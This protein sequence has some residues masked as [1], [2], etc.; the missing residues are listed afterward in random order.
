MASIIR[1][2]RVFRRAKADINITPLIDVLLALIVIFMVISPLTPQGLEA[3]VPQPSSLRTVKT[4]DETLVLSLS[5]DGR[6]RLNQQDVEGSSILFRLQ[7]VLRTRSDRTLFVQ[8]DDEV[9]YNDVA[10]LIDMARGAGAD[11]IGL[12]TQ[13]IAAR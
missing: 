10:Q 11:R 2:R 4:P 13:R 12:M 6:I 8:A 3:N 5:G 1:T 9:L 7:E